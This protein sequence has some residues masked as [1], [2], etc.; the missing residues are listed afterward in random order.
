MDEDKRL[1]VAIIDQAIKDAEYIFWGAAR[2]RKKYGSV[3]ILRSFRWME[4]EHEIKS[5]WFIEI[6]DLAE[7]HESHVYRVINNLKERY[8]FED[9]I[10]KKYMSLSQKRRAGLTTRIKGGR[11]GR[12]MRKFN[13]RST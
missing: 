6:C 7:I 3:D 11:R 12:P 1:W 13:L 2:E 10:F 8:Q 9:S 4:L 5:K